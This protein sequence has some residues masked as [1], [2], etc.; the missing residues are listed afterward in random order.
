MKI[1][2]YCRHCQNRIGEVDGSHATEA[3]LGLSSLTPDEAADI[4]TYNSI[5]NS[6]YVKTVC[7]YCQEALE[8]HPELN[9]L[10]NPLQ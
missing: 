10:S 3:R 1:I 5:E 2:Y 6:T 7:E 9:L 8:A 4:I